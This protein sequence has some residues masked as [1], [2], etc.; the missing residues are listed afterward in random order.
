MKV[1][2]NDIIDNEVVVFGLK[3]IEKKAY[4]NELYNFHCSHDCKLL[5]CNKA[6]VKQIE[7]RFEFLKE[8]TG[9][10]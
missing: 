8:I 9:E 1:N 6:E 3:V 10:K 7:Y 2:Q 5:G 4:Y